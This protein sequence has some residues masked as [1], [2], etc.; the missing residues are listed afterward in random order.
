[1]ELG[2]LF[3]KRHREQFQVLRGDGDFFSIEFLD[4]PV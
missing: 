1:M 4:Q 2:D 3:L